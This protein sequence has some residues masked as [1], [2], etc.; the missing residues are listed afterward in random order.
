MT[1]LNLLPTSSLLREASTVLRRKDDG[2]W[3]DD[4]GTFRPATFSHS[5]TFRSD[6]PIA[7]FIIQYLFGKNRVIF[8]F[9]L[10]VYDFP[11]ISSMNA[12][13]FGGR[14]RNS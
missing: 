9:I 8:L 12:S 10:S 11:N 7:Y 14:P 3:A 4:D 2:E 1:A 6:H 5:H 13:G